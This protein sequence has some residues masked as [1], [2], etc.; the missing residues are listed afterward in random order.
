[1]N[2]NFAGVTKDTWVRVVI[3]VLTLVNTVLIRFGIVEFADVDFN[4]YYEQISTIITVLAS[5]WCAWKNNSF[6]YEAQVADV[7]R[8][9]MVNAGSGSS[10]IECD[11][12]E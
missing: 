1:M 6:T 9:Q 3:L 5:L 4:M 10:V 12:E 11:E 7:D 8:K 2:F